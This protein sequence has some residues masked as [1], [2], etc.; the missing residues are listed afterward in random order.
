MKK[1][2]TLIFLSLFITSFV[3][4][5]HLVKKG[6]NKQKPVNKTLFIQAQ[7]HKPSD[8]RRSDKKQL[9]LTRPNIFK[10]LNTSKQKLD[11][12]VY[13]DT[14][15]EQYTNK[16]YFEYDASGNNILWSEYEW[17]GYWL[18]LYNEYY[19]YD[20][21]GNLTL[22]LYEYWDEMMDNWIKE[23]KYEYTYDGNNSLTERMIYYWNQD[24]MDWEIA[25]KT[26]YIYDGDGVLIYNLMSFMEEGEW[27][28]VLKTEYTYDG[29]GNII[30]ILVLGYFME[31][32]FEYGKTDYTYDG[33][34]NMTQEIYYDWD[35]EDGGWL[36]IDKYAY[37]YNSNGNLLTTI[38]TEWF[39][40]W[41]N[42]NKEENNYDANGNIILQ[43]YLDWDE[44][45]EAWVNESKVD[46][47]YNNDYSFD[48]LILPYIYLI[49]FPELF[50]HM[51][52]GGFGFTWDSETGDWDAED[53]INFHYSEQT[54][55]GITDNSLETIKVYP[56]PAS[57]HV[58]FDLSK[59][60]SSATVKI[61]DLQGKMVISQEITDKTQISID[62]L[63]KGFYIYKL[64]QNGN[65]QS[66]KILIE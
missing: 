18:A 64:L 37:T 11:S 19:A 9:E 63:N 46:I 42:L 47:M 7:K 61:Y 53:I 48:D 59:N 32:W 40:E 62:Y 20:A 5:Q 30:N 33:N 54:V 66:G 39:G 57:E 14:E 36:A 16:G 2:F 65:T 17:V 44:T 8:D 12:I 4:A 3:D 13:V 43:T 34:G 49:E 1:I 41:M 29:N 15:T 58:Y 10:S 31:E 60:S 27:V 50:N 23:L 38:Y 21:N 25:E 45:S 51:T 22:N 56:N 28:I 35:W 24:T 26:E 6:N 52:T 55:T